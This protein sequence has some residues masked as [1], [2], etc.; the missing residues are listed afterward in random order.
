MQ[1][2]LIGE[3]TVPMRDGAVEDLAICATGEA[4]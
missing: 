3:W 4:A 1:K 2:L